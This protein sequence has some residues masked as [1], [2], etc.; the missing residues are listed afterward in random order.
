MSHANVLVAEE[1]SLAGSGSAR[2]TRRAGRVPAVIYGGKAAPQMISLDPRDVKKGLNQ[3][4]FYAH[5]IEIEI[6]GKKQ[7]VLPKAVQF[8]PVSDTPIHLDFLRVTADSI[9]TVAVPVHL[10]NQDKC[11]GLKAGGMLNIVRH[12][13][14]V[15]APATSIPELFEIDITEC[16]I[17]D[18]IKSS[19]IQLPAGCKFVISDRDFTIATIAAPV[20]AKGDEDQAGAADAAAEAPKA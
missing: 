19:A 13:V 20:T 6:G 16:K 10:L 15:L 18:A 7:K 9:I 5:V 3:V 12:N 2:A 1:K 17:G 4:G 11:R 14:E 8:H